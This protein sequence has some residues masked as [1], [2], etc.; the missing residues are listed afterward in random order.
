MCTAAPSFPH[1]VTLKPPYSYICEIAPKT[2]RGMLVAM[3]Q[4]LVTAGTCLGYFTCY[5]SVRIG[6]SISWRLPFIIQAIGGAVL[7]TFC[8]II[9]ESPRW[10]VLHG[11]RDS[12]IQDLKSLG[13]STYEAEK[14]ILGPAEQESRSQPTTLGL[15]GLLTIFKRLHRQRTILGLFIL[16]MVQLCGIDGVLYVS[17]P[18]VYRPLLSFRCSFESTDSFFPV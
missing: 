2:R 3:P 1:C 15:R 16:G 11:H 17:A 10:M 13:V 9:P 8:C 4:L 5:G 7:L 14:D 6:S 18:D 12:A